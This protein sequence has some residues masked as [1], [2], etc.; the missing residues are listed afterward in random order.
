MLSLS[1]CCLFRVFAFLCFVVLCFVMDP[2]TQT[3]FTDIYAQSLSADCDLDLWPSDMVLVHNTSSCPDN[4]LFLNHFQ[5]LP[6]ITKL[7]VR[8]KQVSL[9]SMYNLSA[10]CNLD[11]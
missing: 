1:I 10:D 7:W 6:C 9:K 5:I 3:G 4:Q 8:H 11:L 2:Q